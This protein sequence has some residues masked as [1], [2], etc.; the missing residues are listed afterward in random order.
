MRTD[1]LSLVVELLHAYGIHVFPTALVFRP[2]EIRFET[3]EDVTQ[4]SMVL[5]EA[6]R[7][8]A[9]GILVSMQRSEE[10]CCLE[11]L[12]NREPIAVYRRKHA[13]NRWVYKNDLRLRV[14]VRTTLYSDRPYVRQLELG[15]ETAL[16]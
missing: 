2:T 16:A 3:G 13:T 7:S 15:L 12:L 10:G 6:L 11:I 8:I 5:K 4:H 1:N 9:P 14:A